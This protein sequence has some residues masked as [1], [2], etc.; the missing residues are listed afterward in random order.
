MADYD[1]GSVGYNVE[2]KGAAKATSDLK[3]I[4]ANFKDVTKS[5][6]DFK[7]T[8]VLDSVYAQLDKVTQGTKAWITLEQRR[9]SLLVSDFSYQKSVAAQEVAIYDTKLKA[10]N[11]ITAAIIR[12]ESE[13]KKAATLAASQYQSSIGPRLG[14]GAITGNSI[15][16]SAIEAELDRLSSKYDR[17]YAASK[18]YESEL[19]ELKSAELNSIITTK[20]Y[21]SAVDTLTNE[22]NQFVAGTANSNNV[23]ARQA[24]IMRE[25]TRGSRLYGMAIQ[26]T[27]Y[28]VGD[29][30]VQI[31][32]GTNYFVAFGQQ[33]TQL[34]GLLFLM[35]SQI[36][37][38][39]L[40][41]ASWGLI[42]SIA[43]PLLTAIGAYWLRTS[44]AAKEAKDSYVD[45]INSIKQEVE[46]AHL[47]NLK[48]KFSV[49]SESVAKVLDQIEKINDKIIYAQNQIDLAAKIGGRRSGGILSTYGSEL[50]N[51]NDKKKTLQDQL[52]ILVEQRRLQDLL[53]QQENARN[54]AGAAYLTQIKATKDAAAA[55]AQATASMYG[56]ITSALGITYIAERKLMGNNLAAHVAAAA[57]AAARFADNMARVR[58]VQDAQNAPVIFDPRDPHY[59][60]A[61]ATQAGAFRNGSSYPIISPPKTSGSSGG[62]STIDPVKQLQEQ[63]DLAN[64][65][66]GATEAQKQLI[67]ALGN[68]WSKYSPE[69]I[70]GLTDQIQAQIDLNAHIAEQQGLWDTVSNA[71]T[72]AIMGM[73]EGT[74]TVKDAFR[75][76]AFDIIEQLYKVLIVQRMVGSFD[77]ASGTGSGLA[78]ILGTLIS[79]ARATGGNT[80]AG[81]A[82]LVGEQG[83]EII[84]PSSSGRVLTNSQSNQAMSGGG[85]NITVQNTISVT[86]SD[87]AAVRAEVI[88]MLPQ[89]QA[90]TTAGIIDAKRR[91]GKMSQAFR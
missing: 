8:V 88:K 28:Q 6:K 69:V 81:H 61:R 41:L 64:K 45:A 77:T 46:K 43:I 15:D 48:L 65:L 90:A 23:F 56:A 91:G 71:S 30:L 29:F 73:V 10:I 78:G 27:G 57:D 13:Q 84:V 33:A 63:I 9:L 37:I 53:T 24:G 38:L 25:S 22:Y 85:G 14:L 86:G 51:Q 12:Q 49:D 54:A 80:T 31:Q 21:T 11:A 62:A 60:K 58:V 67:Q 70:K 3:Q 83:P 59:D 68:D 89:I 75:K 40:G 20:E 52:D 50:D 19:K 74:M 44:K 42:L 47:E 5:A 26:Q 18:L 82:Y 39:G 16:G 66:V 34:T 1:L 72:D 32:S 36:K 76:M 2:I 35:N 17:L 87:S 79:G 55:E 7:A 4:D